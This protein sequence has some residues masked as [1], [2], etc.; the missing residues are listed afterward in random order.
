MHE[1]RRPEIVVKIDSL[2]RRSSSALTQESAL[3]GDTGEQALV[4]PGSMASPGNAIKAHQQFAKSTAG[5]NLVKELVIGL[6]L[7]L[8]AG[9]VWKVFYKQRQHTIPTLP[10]YEAHDHFYTTYSILLLGL[11]PEM[12]HTILELLWPR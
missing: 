7:G 9:S 8:A 6:S 10:K 3:R 1:S 11:V 5:I 4:G 12:C 2:W